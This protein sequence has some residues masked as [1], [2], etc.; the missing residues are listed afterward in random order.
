[1]CSIQSLIVRLLRKA[2]AVSFRECAEHSKELKLDL[3]S[4][5]LTGD[6]I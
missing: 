2:R 1:M 4:H 6:Y 5:I 3:I